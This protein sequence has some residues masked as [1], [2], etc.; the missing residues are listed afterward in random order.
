MR[1]RI[2]QAVP[3]CL[4]FAFLLLLSQALACG[5][6]GNSRMRIRLLLLKDPYE[7]G[8]VAEFQK[9]EHSKETEQID[10]AFWG[11]SQGV[12][13]YPEL[14]RES[15]AVIVA[16]SGDSRLV[17]PN[18]GVLGSG[19]G[20]CLLGRGLAEALFG[21][22]SAIG[23]TVTIGQRKYKVEGMLDQAEQMVVIPAESAGSSPPKAGTEANQGTDGFLLDRVSLNIPEDVSQEEAVRQ[24]SSEAGITG[25]VIPVHWYLR[26]AKGAARLIPLL[27]YV[28]LAAGLV[29]RVF[30][31]K[32]KHG[33]APA[34]FAACVLGAAGIFVLGLSLDIPRDYLPAKWSDFEFWTG[35]WEQK[36][37]E[38]AL[39]IRTEKSQAELWAC[40]VLNRTV[41]YSLG[42]AVL[43]A[44]AFRKLTVRRGSTLF[45]LT[46][47]SL[48]A[49]YLFLTA[50]QGVGPNLAK[51]RILWLFLPLCFT[52]KYLMNHFLPQPKSDAGEEK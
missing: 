52:V 12:V 4:A 33:I 13:R 7:A 30:R 23:Q 43:G 14:N 51:S 48:L 1:A 6:E 49:A 18:A 34:L 40:G 5:E 26:W 2:W 50:K 39:L 9:S 20:G 47:A 10:F 27:L 25:E 22:P 32:G 44:L 15:E 46:A 16:V 45:L 38:W 3:V 41:W 35:L 17:F 37:K 21:H 24:F 8:A 42:A 31:W 29:K 28:V 19:E 11:E 36:E